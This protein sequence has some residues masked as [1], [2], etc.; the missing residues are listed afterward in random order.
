M[1]MHPLRRSNKRVLLQGGKEPDMQ[2]V[3]ECQD[4]AR[5]VLTCQPAVAACWPWQAGL[6]TVHQLLLA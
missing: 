2:C 1:K 6:H 5:T 3:K 4:G